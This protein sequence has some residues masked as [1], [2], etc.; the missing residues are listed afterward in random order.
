MA[1]F[2]GEGLT[3]DDVSLCVQYADFLP[4]EADVRSRLSRNI[5]LSVPFASAAM[6]TVTEGKMAIGM[7]MVGGVGV[8]HKN[9]SPE[10]QAHEVRKVKGY[11]NGLIESPV[12]FR[13]DTTIE[14]LIAEKDR[15]NYTFSG[16]PIVDDNDKLVGILT[17]RDL[18]FLRDYSLQVRSVMTTEL[19]TA[20]VGT[21]LDQAFATMLEHHVGKLPI[22]DESGHLAGLYSFHDVVSLIDNVESLINRD[23]HHRLRAVA[24][25]GPYDEERA[26]LLVRAGV[27]AVVID[28]AHGHTKGVIDTIREIKRLYAGV[29]VIA[30]NVG[31]GAGAKALVDAGADGIKVGIGPGSICTTRVVAGVG[32]PQLTAIF[33]TTRGYRHGSASHRRWRYQAIRRCAEG[34][35]GWC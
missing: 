2:E 34:A 27:D 10:T 8:I 18:K 29:D 12:V 17:A 35:G 4:E 1:R 22:V 33:E 13:Q 11:L 3:F 19:L 23:S 6:D 14:D 15:N 30:G 24:A 20:P 5:S 21:T 9:L 31:S 25:I 7:A 28:T 16:F 26:E 32:I